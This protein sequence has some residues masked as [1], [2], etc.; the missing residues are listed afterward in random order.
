MSCK[1]Q[2]LAE[3]VDEISPIKSRLISLQNKLWNAPGC[4]REA[5]SLDRI[6]AR[7]ESWQVKAKEA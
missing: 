4:A 3:V 1:R 7:L 5:E 2:L 6:I